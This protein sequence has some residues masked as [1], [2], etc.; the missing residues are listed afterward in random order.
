MRKIFTAFVVIAIAVSA[1]SYKYDLPKMPCIFTLKL[2][3][4]KDGKTTQ[5]DKYFVN[6]HFLR[7]RL[8]PDRQGEDITTVYRYDIT[9]KEDDKEMIGFVVSKN[10]ECQTYWT[11][12]EEYLN[13]TGELYESFFGYLSKISWDSKE[14]TKYNGK[15]CT[16]YRVTTNREYTLYVYEGYPYATGI[17]SD[18]LIYE[19]E[20]EVPLSTFKLEGCEGDFAKTPA[21]N[22]SKC[23]DTVSSSSSDDD[24]ASS[25][26]AFVALVFA[27]IAASLVALF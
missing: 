3:E 17:D 26:Q 1:E 9:K 12:M 6:D 8:F 7:T 27:V 13:M 4:V 11:P 18:V 23:P 16:L 20:W 10:D 22:Y 19:W 25:T 15:K 14:E 24:A 21:A 5:W 2:S